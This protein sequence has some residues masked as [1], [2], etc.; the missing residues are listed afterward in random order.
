MSKMICIKKIV[1][2][3]VFFCFIFIPQITAQTS[4]QVALEFLK[5]GIECLMTGDYNNA[6]VNFNEVLRRNTNSALTYVMR[7]RAYYELNDFE[8]AIADCT[9][10]IRFD[11]NNTT[12]FILRGNAHRKIGDLT[13]AIDDWEAALKINPNIE[14][15]KLNLELARKSAGE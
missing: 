4:N 12:A 6:I 5:R 10:A 2:F 3:V 8:R 1:V 11:R 13:K 7:G 15:A 9:Q 14:E